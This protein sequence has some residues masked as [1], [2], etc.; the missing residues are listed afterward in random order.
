MPRTCSVLFAFAILGQFAVAQ[1]ADLADDPLNPQNYIPKSSYA[2]AGFGV[3]LGMVVACLAWSI[4]YRAAYM[5]ILMVSAAF[6]ATGLILRT[7]KIF[8]YDV[9][10]ANDP[11]NVSTFIAMRL[12]AL[13]PAGGLFI[14]VFMSFV[15][16]AHHL[17]AADLVPLG[18]NLIAG[19][20]VVVEI[21]CIAIQSVGAA[22]SPSSTTN[23]QSLGKTV[24]LTHSPLE[25]GSHYR[26][27][28]LLVVGSII[29]L[30][31]LA[32]FTVLYIV[33]IYRLKNSRPEEWKARPY[34]RFKHFT[35]FV[36]MMGFACQN[37]L[38]HT[39]YRLLEAAQGPSGKLAKS[40]L[41]FYMLDAL[42]LLNVILGFV[43]LWPPYYLRPAMQIRLGS[44]SSI[45]LRDSPG[46]SKAANP[47]RAYGEA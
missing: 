28:Q 12:M 15:K 14:L 2:Y 34:G 4:R 29:Q 33:F 7:G 38:I 10:F 21:I 8:S 13:I 20:Y 31:S 30:V 23:N 35:L 6:Y 25:L 9:V 41:W 42:Q 18:P 37:L 45:E 11:Y 16:L 17:D 24:R 43:V 36:Y 27:N 22:I 19:V 47:E 39:A 5:F 3:Y 32:T 46:Q 40:E 1:E 26:A 44:S